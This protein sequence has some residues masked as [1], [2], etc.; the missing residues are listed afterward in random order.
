MLASALL[1]RLFM[2]ARGVC[3]G[4]GKWDTVMETGTGGHSSQARPVLYPWHR[5]GDQGL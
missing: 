5:A 1:L 3:A 2:M 4:L